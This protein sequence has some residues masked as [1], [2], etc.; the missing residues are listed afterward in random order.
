MSVYFISP[1][2]VI[3][4][5]YAL[6]R[7]YSVCLDVNKRHLQIY[8]KSGDHK[9]K[10]NPERFGNTFLYVKE[11]GTTGKGLAK[12]GGKGREEKA[13]AVL[14]I[15]I[16]GRFSIQTSVHPKITKVRVKKIEVFVIPKSGKWD[17][18]SLT[19]ICFEPFLLE[20]EEDVGNFK[21]QAATAVHN[22]G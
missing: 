2:F 17:Q 14:S 18:A 16:S 19:N 21:F 4:R 13:T 22:S 15:D 1:T 6:Q 20:F 9:L 8:E 11:A 12:T 3:Q 5:K 10:D 7:T